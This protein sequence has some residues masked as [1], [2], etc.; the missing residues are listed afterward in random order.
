[1]TGQ[2]GTHVGACEHAGEPML[3]D[4]FDRHREVGHRRQR[5]VV[6]GENGP[7]RRGNVKHRASHAN[8]AS[9]TSPW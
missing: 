2:D 9:L 1:M 8:C 6:H 4:E 3:V 7:A 5:R